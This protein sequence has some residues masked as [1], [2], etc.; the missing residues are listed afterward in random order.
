VV[1]SITNAIFALTG[2][3]IWRSPIRPEDLKRA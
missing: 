3:R 2:R 1:P